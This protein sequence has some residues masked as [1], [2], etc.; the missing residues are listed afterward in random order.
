M[1]RWALIFFVTSIVS[2][3]FGFTRVAAGTAVLGR[4]CFTVSVGLFLIF[5]VVGLV[6]E[7]KVSSQL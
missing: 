6:V 3:V 5:L 7:R 2:G 4:W 1:M